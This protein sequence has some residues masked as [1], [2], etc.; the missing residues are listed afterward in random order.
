MG[1]QAFRA[2]WDGSCPEDGNRTGSQGSL[3]T[4]KVLRTLSSLWTWWAELRAAAGPSVAQGAQGFDWGWGQGQIWAQASDKSR[5]ALGL[6]G[7]G[8]R[9]SAGLWGQGMA[10]CTPQ[11]SACC[12]NTCPLR[13]CNTKYREQLL[14]QNVHLIRFYMFLLHCPAE[15]QRNVGNFKM[16]CKALNFFWMGVSKTVTVICHL[17]S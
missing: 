12:H 2:W 5:A 3:G 1:S 16:A 4:D 10:A 13:D 8:Q 17:D 6:L 9:E 14:N 7:P 15:T 11:H